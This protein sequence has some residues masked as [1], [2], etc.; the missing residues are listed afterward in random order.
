MDI[1][2]TRASTWS[3]DFYQQMLDY[4]EGSG[5]EDM[6][7]QL[8]EWRDGG[9]AKLREWEAIEE[10]ANTMSADELEKVGRGAHLLRDQSISTA[11]P[12]SSSK[13]SREDSE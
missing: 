5:N 12:R 2:L 11:A 3:E 7:R 13:A 1:D 10:V 4:F 6:A 8:R 9:E